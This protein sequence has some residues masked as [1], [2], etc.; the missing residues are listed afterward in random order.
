MFCRIQ[1][2]NTERSRKLT[3]TERR[4]ALL[5][6]LCKRRF[7]TRENLAFEFGVSKRT[8]E[9]DVTVLSINYPVYTV[10]GNGGGIRV[11]DGFDLDKP[12]LTE[13]QTAFL[14][15]LLPAL[16]AEDKKAMAEILNDCGATKIWR[17]EK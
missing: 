17:K 10:Q 15:K 13:K 4:R 3:A 1:A 9:Y 5:E 14:V 16:S 6:T 11:M 7:D 2:R 12:R 8:I